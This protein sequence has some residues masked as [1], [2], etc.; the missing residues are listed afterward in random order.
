MKPDAV[1]DAA[2][3]APLAAVSSVTVTASVSPGRSTSAMVTA[4]KGV[5][6]VWSVTVWLAPAPPRVGASFTAVTVMVAVSLAALKAVVPPLAVVSAVDPALPLVRS[7]ARKVK[8]PVVAFAV[9][10][11]KRTRSAARSSSAAVPDRLP[12][13]VQLPPLST[14]YCQVP[15]PASAAV[16]AMPWTAPTSPST[17]DVPRIDATVWPA[18]DVCSS[19]IAVRDGLAG[20]SA[21]ASLTAVETTVV[22]LSVAALLSWTEMVKVVVSVVPAATRLAAGVNTRPRIAAVAAAAVPVK[23]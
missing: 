21:G 6:V 1:S 15:F 5:T 22:A 2:V 14:E 18:L 20:V 16:M 11:T 7:Q 10:G 23:V 12:N 13:A 19:V 8:L 4:A 3:K 17:T 9:F